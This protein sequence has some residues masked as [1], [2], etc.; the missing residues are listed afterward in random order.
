MAL[1]KIVMMVYD[2]FCLFVSCYIVVLIFGIFE[3]TI[4]EIDYCL[5]FKLI[6][7]CFVVS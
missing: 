2:P 6:K 5:L 7:S 4:F 1:S 3:F